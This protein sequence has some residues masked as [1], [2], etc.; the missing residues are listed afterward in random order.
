VP[1]AVIEAPRTDGA[2]EAAVDTTELTLATAALTAGPPGT[3]AATTPAPVLTTSCAVRA[4][5][6]PK[7]FRGVCL[8]TVGVMDSVPIRLPFST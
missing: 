4:N 6:V 5:T 3:I 7:S 8:A 2:D 1:P